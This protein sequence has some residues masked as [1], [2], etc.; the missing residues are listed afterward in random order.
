MP[1]TL[2]L[3]PSGVPEYC[4]QYPAFPSVELEV[5]GVGQ[6]GEYGRRYTKLAVPP[7]PRPSSRRS[8]RSDSSCYPEAVGFGPR[9][10]SGQHTASQGSLAGAPYVGCT[11]DYR[12]RDVCEVGGA[13][14]TPP[15]PPSGRTSPTQHY[16]W[17][18]RRN[19]EPV[20]AEAA[21]GP[22]D[23]RLPS[24][25]PPP[26]ASTF[27]TAASAAAA[28]AAPPL[29]PT[30]PTPI[31]KK[32][33]KSVSIA[34]ESA[35]LCLE[36]R[37]GAGGMLRVVECGE[38]EVRLSAGGG[39]SD[40]DSDSDGGALVA[41]AAAPRPSAARVAHASSTGPSVA[42]ATR[43][44][45]SSSGG[46][47][48]GAGR[49]GLAT[50]RR[51]A[52]KAE[53]RRLS[54]QR[55]SVVRP[56]SAGVGGGGGGT[57]AAGVPAQ[58][59]GRR[60]LQGA[61]AARSV[62]AGQRQRGG[63]GGG[64]GGGAVVRPQPQEDVEDAWLPAFGG[65]LEAE[66]AARGVVHEQEQIF[67][68]RIVTQ[69]LRSVDSLPEQA[70]HSAR[71]A[72]PRWH[73]RQQQQQQ[74][75]ELDL[76]LAAEQ[77]FADPYH[78]RHHHP[79]PAHA[80]A[81][82]PDVASD[83]VMRLLRGLGSSPPPSAALH[84]PLSPRRRGSGSGGGG[85]GSV[86]E[87]RF[88]DLPL[89]PPLPRGASPPVSPATAAGADDAF[90]LSVSPERLSPAAAAP[91]QQPRPQQQP[92]FRSGVGSPAFDVRPRARMRSPGARGTTV[93]P[94][95]AP[96]ALLANRL[97][98]GGGQGAALLR[99]S[100][101]A[102]SAPQVGGR[103]EAAP[104]RP[105]GTS[106]QLQPFSRGSLRSLW[107]QGKAKGEAAAAAAAATAARP[108]PERPAAEEGKA[109]GWRVIE[110]YKDVSPA[111]GHV[112]Q[113]LQQ[114]QQQ[115]QPARPLLARERRRL[116]VGSEQQWPQQQQ[117]HPTVF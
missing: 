72:Q 29:P 46:G 59:A 87:G 33:K 107:T 42:A 39:D 113:E 20:N 41:A 78:R 8:S 93:S 106:P 105:A 80:H 17:A 67:L 71:E 50:E 73:E 34:E 110:G 36:G 45:R 94:A 116:G 44:T 114:Q 52:A 18:E 5:A 7:P 96:F 55:G 99:A 74:H 61:R 54:Q 95:A 100:S 108:V 82:E 97:D 51:A 53:A 104:A 47:A 15:P 70:A 92:P 11:T 88:R 40:S 60:S 12:Y 14:T 28:S 69:R 48:A 56:Q 76:Y 103:T 102:S 31:L 49:P 30:P 112:R 19:E 21:P 23:T 32:P 62:S 16:R 68:L 85:G 75:E 98:D 43:R 86:S 3:G 10:A 79:Q 83:H 101:S 26:P 6:P 66:A 35:A 63:G 117:Q 13:P 81:Y 1:P 65:L 109:S 115:Q 38:A 37:S 89:P 64:G 91:A 9:G 25:T 22:W 57:A 2:Y 90:D 111:R 24:T 84:P 77:E 58:R 27:S 4:E